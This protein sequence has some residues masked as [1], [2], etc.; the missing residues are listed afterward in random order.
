MTIGRSQISKQIDGK[1]SDPKK[2]NKEK[3]K[4]QVKKSNKKNPL[5][6]TFTV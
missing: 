6:R 1:L 5:A 3:K 4:L 2:K